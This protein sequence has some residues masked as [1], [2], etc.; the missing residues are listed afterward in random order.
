[1]NDI[2]VRDVQRRHGNQYFKGKSFDNSCPYGP[3]I[4]TRDEI[5]DP[6]NLQLWTR[7][8]GEEKQHGYTKNMYDG[9]PAIIASLSEGMTIEPGDLV[10]TG[11]PEGVGMGR[12]PQEW[13]R[14]D[15][16]IECEVERVGKI[17]N[18]IVGD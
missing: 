5:P 4:V 18:R 1:M 6:A 7:V 14:P 2:S 11:T 3:W 9:I 8:N 10:A 16:I 15:D 13:L 12:T 17:R